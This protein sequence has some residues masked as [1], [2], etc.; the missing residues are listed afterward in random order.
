MLLEYAR[1]YAKEP[2]T[3]S[4][5]LALRVQ[6]LARPID[7]TGVAELRLEMHMNLPARHQQRES[8]VVH[9]QAQL[10]EC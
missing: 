8:T 5:A 6:N 1:Q 10:S 7:P 4:L 9:V 3:F 2:I